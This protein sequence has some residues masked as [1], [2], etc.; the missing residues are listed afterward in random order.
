MILLYL[1]L[2]TS[3]FLFSHFDSCNSDTVCSPKQPRMQI[4]DDSP[5]RT[6]GTQ[7]IF[8]NQI[9]GKDSILFIR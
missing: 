8:S 1:Y 5:F 7:S 3:F 2:Y 9:S 4:S 6:Q